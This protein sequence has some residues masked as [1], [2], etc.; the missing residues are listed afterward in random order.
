[1]KTLNDLL[2]NLPQVGRLE[3]I[4]LAPARMEALDEPDLAELIVGRGIV[5]EHHAKRRPTKRE[6]TLVQWEHLPV[7]GAVLQRDVISPILLRRNLAVSGINLL[8][9]KNATFQIGDVVLQGTGPCEPCSRMESVLGPGGYNAVRGHGGITA[10]V[11][12]GG[13]IKKGDP[14]QF[15]ALESPVGSKLSKG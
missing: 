12:Q 6:V 10:K 13:T 5:G 8:A 14:V 9:L 1:M 2:S 15:V 3:W 7:I 11:I 4:G